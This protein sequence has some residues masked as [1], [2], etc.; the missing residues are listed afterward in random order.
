MT[1][2]QIAGL[3]TATAFWGLS[4]IF[5]RKAARA[6]AAR[7]EKLDMFWMVVS[8]SLISPLPLLDLALTLDSPCTVFDAF[9]DIGGTSLFEIFYIVF[10]STRLDEGLFPDQ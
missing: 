1:A 10:A 2:L 7:G 4:N 6:V 5:V 8:S 3:L 9:T